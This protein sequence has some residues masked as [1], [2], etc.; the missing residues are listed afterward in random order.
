MLSTKG[1]GQESTILK[2]MDVQ[3]INNWTEVSKLVANDCIADDVFG[4]SLSISDDGLTLVVSTPW[5]NTN[6]L[7]HSGQIYTYVRPT[8]NDAWTEVSKLV[9]SDTTNNDWFGYSLSLS[10]D[11]LNLVVGARNKN[12]NGLN[13]SGQVYTYVRPTISDDWIEVSKLT[14]SDAVTK[15]YFGHSV[16][17]SNNGLNLVVGTPWKNIKGLT[18]NGQVYTYTRETVNDDWI[19]IS[20]LRASDV[21][22][23]NDEFGYSVCMSDDGLSLVVNT[24]CK[25]TDG[26]SHSG[27][28]YTYSRPTTNDAWTEISKLKANDTDARDK[29][30]ESLSLSSD[31][32]V[33]VVSAP[34][35]DTAC[36]D[37][38]K[39]SDNGQVYTYVRDNTNDTWT[40]VSKLIA[41]DAVGYDY[42]GASL[43][44]SSDGLTLAV[45]ASWKDIGELS[46][47]GQVYTY[48]RDTISDD[49]T[50]VSKIT[51]SDA[52]TDDYFGASLDM[53]SNG[54]SLVINSSHKSTD[55]LENNGQV[56]TYTYNH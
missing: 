20:K 8:I 6:K 47:S 14:A 53:S 56:Y 22:I 3:S 39:V 49:W 7:V 9:A 44:L 24:V 41:S 21:S 10:G 46:S 30:G 32:L 19:E 36:K 4:A 34:W 13:A 29:F 23:I 17:I 12:A 11:G 42:F 15:D 25:K 5:K 50:E 27:Q 31:G 52:S 16:T 1:E 38:D 28:I 48:T 33:L 55:G 54:S 26:I 45:G 51:A 37:T 40:E 18:Y 2:H 43:S 35:K